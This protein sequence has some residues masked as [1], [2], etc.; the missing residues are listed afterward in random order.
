MTAS[1][2]NNTALPRRPRGRPS[3]HGQ[4]YADTRAVLDRLRSGV[5]EVRAG[6]E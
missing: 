6:V 4:S 5:A 3:R 1:A 2:P